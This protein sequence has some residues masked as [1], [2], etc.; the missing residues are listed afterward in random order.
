MNN[1]PHRFTEISHFAAQT[2]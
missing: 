2:V 1:L